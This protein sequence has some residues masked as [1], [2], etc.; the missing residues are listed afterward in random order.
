VTNI[1]VTPVYLEAAMKKIKLSL[2]AT[3]LGLTGCDTL[4]DADQGD[5]MAVVSRPDTLNIIDLETNTIVRQCQ[6][7]S[8]PVPGTV[9][10]SP[11]RQTVYG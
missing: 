1:F 9:E 2:I 5:F 6:L 4:P 10:I 11:D 8:S 3:L 7:P